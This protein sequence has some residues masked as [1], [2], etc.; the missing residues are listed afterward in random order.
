MYM[1][2][3]MTFLINWNYSYFYISANKTKTHH[4]ISRRSFE[5]NN[6]IRYK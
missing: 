1:K 5:E 6:M 2:A 3:L 4:R